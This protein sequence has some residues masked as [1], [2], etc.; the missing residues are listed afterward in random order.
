ME[1]LNRHFSKEDKQ[2][3][4]E[5]MKDVQHHSLL[6]KHKSKP[7]CDII[8]HRSELPSSESLQTINAGEGLENRKPSYT[9]GVNANWYSHC[10]E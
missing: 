5:Y 2:R 8:A 3:A 7:Q 10:G 9:V 4:Y 6:E 1:V